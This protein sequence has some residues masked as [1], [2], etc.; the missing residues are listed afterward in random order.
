MIQTETI[1]RQP[2]FWQRL[3][4]GAGIH[5]GEGVAFSLLFGQ[6]FFLGI[7]LITYYS[8]ANALFLSH[9]SAQKLPYVYMIAAAIIISA[10][11]I[12]LRLQS[13]LPFSTLLIGNLGLMFLMITAL[14]LLLAW[15]S[16]HWIYFFMLVWV[17]VLW[18][19]G[20]LGLWTLAGRLFTSRQGKRLFSLIMAGGVLSIILVGFLN[21]SL[22]RW[23][24]TPNLLWV[25]SASLLAA[26]WL[27]VVTTRRFKA[28][29]ALPEAESKTISKPDQPR[30]KPIFR[31]RYV[32][33]IF[34]FTI[35][36]TI[37]TY[38]LDYAFIGQAGAKLTDADQLSKFFGSYMGV[39]TLVTLVVLLLI[40][41]RF[42]RRFGV[43]GGLLVD[44][45]LVALGT[46]GV[47]LLS[48]FPD[49]AGI[50][51]WV[52]V[53]TKMSD[54]VSVVAMNNT[55][56]RIMYQPLPQHAR[57]RV[58]TTVES[59]VA[60]L[61][62]GISGGLLLLFTALWNLTP[63]QA[64]YILAVIL[65]GWLL[66]GILLGRQYYGALQNALDRRYLD[67]SEVDIFAESAGLA[68]L[69]KHL[70]SENPRDILFA[71]EMLAQNDPAILV[72]A[73]PHLLTHAN[74]AVRLTAVQQLTSQNEDA[75]PWLEVLAQDVLQ[76][77][78]VRAAALQR[79][80]SMGESAA[81][82]LP[83]YLSDS[84]IE[85]RFAGVVGALQ[86]H[87]LEVILA[88]G[89]ILSA[90]QNDSS[91]EMRCF[92][93]RVIGAVGNV[94][95]HRNL[96]SLLNDS[97]IIV[98]QEALRACQNVHH[99]QLWPLVLDALHSADTR[100][101]ARK[102]LIAGGESALPVIADKLHQV[103]AAPVTHDLIRI[104]GQIGGP[105]VNP[106]LQTLIATPRERVRSEVLHV[107]ARNHYRAEPEMRP[108]IFEQVDA[109]IAALGQLVQMSIELPN[110][111]SHAV[112]P[113][114]GILTQMRARGRVRIF[115]LLALVYDA[116]DILRVQTNLLSEQKDKRANATEVLDV[117]LS[118][119][120]RLRDRLVPM[121]TAQTIADLAK[122]FSAPASG[123]AEQLRALYTQDNSQLKNNWL[124]A[125]VLYAL[126]Q[127]APEAANTILESARQHPEEIVRQTAQ[128]VLCRHNTVDGDFPMMLTI[129]KVLIL[130]TVS[131]FAETP[132]DLLAEL[133]VYLE[134]RDV[135]AGQVIFEKGDPGD[136]MY[137]IVAGKVRV[138]D[139]D[140]TLNELSDRDVFG[141]MALLDPAP[142]S[143]S[144][145]AS[146]DTRL[147]CLDHDPF[148]EAVDTRSEIA[149]G[150]IQVLSQKMRGMIDEE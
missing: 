14:R 95:F 130:K 28:A 96:L 19:L 87:S 115:N 119:D 100:S 125:C 110:Q 67:G 141:E 44:P 129:E 121:I 59:V 132:D 89:D 71:I 1:T 69:E 138:H 75:L 122:H 105:R 114:S 93:A 77:I 124:A 146:E 7:A 38:V 53:A 10:G 139:G 63:L 45:I 24:G 116:Q 43:R 23:F 73:L 70:Q 31:D 36:S 99:A 128:G 52:V 46:L 80:A 134:E 127:L 55:S 126:P 41:N 81:Q 82:I 136:S 88:A 8:S 5:D 74:A 143:A 112:Q 16:A 145:T 47:I 15:S 54:E 56:V 39:S 9:F 62:M 90:A 6:S 108:A 102:A 66:M 149:R 51:F 118:Q 42:F 27:L 26:F 17:R 35:L 123:I 83:A 58:Q 4:R 103:D 117:I 57:S 104:C 109:E 150:V 85:L 101:E 133:A 30:G 84:N 32:W 25:T 2:G 86:S 106:I 92:A 76:P 148:Y 65:V 107:L 20:N 37:G 50:I 48:N 98:R 120:R 22:I 78:E 61:S 140:R 72:N 142:R 40:S 79:L 111:L 13:S 144:I 33:F 97:E 21:S 18:V 68:A 113:L 34:L 60:P 64:V 29:L 147:L 49:M 94:G 135:A 11:L 3:V 137:I 91:P 12:F 131:I